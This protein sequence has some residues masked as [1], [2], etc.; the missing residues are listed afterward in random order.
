MG[1]LQ[2]PVT[3]RAWLQVSQQEQAELERLLASIKP[4]MD[5]LKKRKE[6][7][8]AASAGGQLQRERSLVLLETIRD[9]LNMDA[10]TKKKLV[11]R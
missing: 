8:M 3:P 9:E 1:T 5:L 6:E 4:T 2:A 10:E 11:V 7:A